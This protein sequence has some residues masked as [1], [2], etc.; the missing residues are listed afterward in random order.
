MQVFVCPKAANLGYLRGVQWKWSNSER[1]PYLLQCRVREFGVEQNQ[2]L[3]RWLRKCQFD[4]WEHDQ[5]FV[6][7]ICCA[8]WF[9]FCLC[10]LTDKWKQAQIVMVGYRD[11]IESLSPTRCYEC[12]RVC[13]PV[14]LRGYRRELP[15]PSRIARSVDLKITFV[16]TS[17]TVNA[18]RWLRNG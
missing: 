11:T 1:T 14:C 7:K 15:S 3:A 16:E 13:F 9:Y 17:A 12:F 10:S 8:V 6:R 4:A 2:R 5:L 18:Q